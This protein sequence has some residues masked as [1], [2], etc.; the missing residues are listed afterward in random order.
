MYPDNG[1]WLR[2]KYV[3]DNFIRPLNVC[4][5]LD[6]GCSAN[7]MKKLHYGHVCG[8]DIEGNPDLHMNLED[9]HFFT[10]SPNSFDCVISLHTLEHIENM[11]KI[12]RKIIQIA[13]RYIVFS[14]PNELRWVYLLQKFKAPNNRENGFFPRNRHK[15][16]VSYSQCRDF[17]HYLA[18]TYDLKLLK[19][20]PILGDVSGIIHK[21]IGSKL[22]NLMPD[23]C[24]VV[25]K[26]KIYKS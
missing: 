25:F 15:W 17:S 21:I 24:V 4:S 14:F 22:P 13:D 11:H 12:I 3:Y 19:C 18:N 7:H 9:K 10:F 8:V 5:I 6:V 2:N 1:R 20:E 23:G 16:F 26:K